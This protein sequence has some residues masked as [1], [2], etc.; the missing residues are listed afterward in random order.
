MIRLIGWLPTDLTAAAQA[1]R[2]VALPC[3]HLSP[4][5]RNEV[6]LLTTELVSNAVVHGAGPPRLD[7]SVD[8]DHVTVGVTDRG[9]GVPVPGPRFEWP[10]GRN[11][12]RVVQSLADGWGVEPTPEQPGKR[13]WFDLICSDATLPESVLE[14]D[15]RVARA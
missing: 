1:R 13:V 14:P 10:N 4:K 6:L 3:A 7:V 11:G 8:G 15:L 2:F 5:A 9:D 12:L